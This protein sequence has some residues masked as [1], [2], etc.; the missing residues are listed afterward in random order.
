MADQTTEKKVAE[1]TPEAKGK[2]A[3]KKFQMPSAYVIVFLVLILI[4]VLTYFIPVS[5]RDDSGNVIFNAMFDKD[6][7]QIINNVGPQPYGFWGNSKSLR[8]IFWVIHT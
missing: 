6:N 3:K 1:A 2:K 4:T 7:G 8:C 5:M